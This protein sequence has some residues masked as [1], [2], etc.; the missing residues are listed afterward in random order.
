LALG[1]FGFYFDVNGAEELDA[2]SA[3]FKADHDQKAHKKI[4]E[5][6]VGDGVDGLG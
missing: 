3:E 5:R 4:V 6:D 2:E 1:D